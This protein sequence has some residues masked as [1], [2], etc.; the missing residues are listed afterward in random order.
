MSGFFGDVHPVTHSQVDT[1]SCPLSTVSTVEH[2]IDGLSSLLSLCTGFRLCPQDPILLIR[3]KNSS[4]FS[5]LSLLCQKA[6]GHFLSFAPKITNGVS[7]K[8]L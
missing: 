4:S 1:H 7:Q 5:F 3:G 6:R 8:V 2:A